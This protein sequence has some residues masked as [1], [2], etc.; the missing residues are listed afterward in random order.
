MDAEKADPLDSF[1]CQQL[2][3]G[4]SLLRFA[5]DLEND[6]R[7]SHTV[8]GLKQLR[9]MLLLGFFFG[10]SFSVF[11]YFLT[12]QGFSSS[13]V[14]LRLAV[15]QPMLLLMLVATMSP[16]GQRLLTP[17]GIV[18]GLVIGA[19]SFL[20]AT[21]AELRSIGAAVTGALVSTI[22]IYFFLGLRFWPAT[23]TAITVMIGFFIAEF[24][25]AASGAAIFYNGMFLCFT[26]LIGAVGS[27][28]LEHSRREAFLET[29]KL[30]YLASR[31]QLTGIANRKAFDEHLATSWAQCK[32]DRASLVVAL[33]DIDYFKAYNDIYGHQA[34]D[35]CLA[36]VAH[37]IAKAS[38][39]PLDLAARYG[40]EE[41][42]VLL[43][44]CTLEQGEALIKRVRERVQALNIA[45]KGSEVAPSIT[46][47]AGVA[48]VFPHA[49]QRS[50]QGTVQMADE[51]MYT[52]KKAGRN[53]VRITE[54][55]H[56]TASQTGMFRVGDSLEIAQ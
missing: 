10:L 25:A 43:P 27:Y 33:I 40:G 45:H 17:L 34:G 37:E 50:A 3:R 24:V 42:V 31:D 38:R 47:S 51:S 16:T 5:D 35:K 32:R 6:F 48:S 23:A 26:N 54:P 55:K 2:D 53:R 39:R 21:T 15:N 36:Q 46:I 13:S 22:Y 12:G 49:A 29:R 11:D 7:A 52:A 4:F 1:Y 41:F 18:V 14:P 8:S 28:N 44:G 56:V 9:V 30:E 19:S 20:F